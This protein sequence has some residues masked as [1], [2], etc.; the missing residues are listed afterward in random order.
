[1]HP[2][3]KKLIFSF[4]G[5]L[6]LLLGLNIICGLTLTIRDTVIKSKYTD[7]RAE[8]P[9]YKNH[10]YTQQIFKEFNNLH[11]EYKSYIGWR[12]VPY[13]GQT[14][15]IDSLGFRVTPLSAEQSTDSTKQRV[16][17][18]GGSTIWGTGVDDYHTI[19]AIYQKMNTDVTVINAGESGYDSR[20]SLELLVNILAKKEKVNSA[21]FYVGVNEI[22]RCRKIVGT[23]AYNYEKN[24]NAKIHEVKSF[25]RYIFTQ[26]LEQIWNG[27]AV[28]VGG[29]Q[30][31]SD[32]DLVC[33]CTEDTSR[34]DE[35][36]ENLYFNLS[37]AKLLV[38]NQG[39]KFIAVLQ[40]V[41]Y[42]GKPTLDYLSEYLSKRDKEKLNYL[43]LYNK[44]FT[45]PNKMMYD[46]TQS[47]NLQEPIYIDYCHLNAQGNAIIA[48][49]IDL[50]L[51]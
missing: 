46:L 21:I 15:T 41:A 25:F 30:D 31:V 18:F 40:P 38:E 37:V 29:G 43:C 50:L 5:L 48:S 19:P 14:V 51:K 24:F 32:Y 28:K 20:Q 3:I 23:N 7:P 45:H 13:K 35:V 9:T 16:Y 42:V 6:I 44:I 2:F 27:F 10:E 36:V 12:R 17:F 39:G 26:Y 4:I 8:L 47:L 34:T 22:N 49:E 1:M 33:N 11:T